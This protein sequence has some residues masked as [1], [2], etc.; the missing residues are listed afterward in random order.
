MNKIRFYIFGTPDGFDIYQE[1]PDANIT[2][3]YQCFYDESIKE[4]TRLAVHR[5][6]NGDVSYTFL[7]YHLFSSGNRS[8]AFIGL[9][10]VFSNGSYFD[11]SSLY[12]LLEYAYNDI[13][14]RGKLLETTSDGNSARFVTAKFS[15]EKQEVRRIE[16]FII[17]Q[18]NSEE[19]S[20]EFS[21]FDSSFEAGKQNAI[22]KIP[23]QIYND[24]I[25]EKRLNQLV[26]DSLKKYSWLSL[27][28]D[29]IKPDNQQPEQIIPIPTDINEELDPITKAQYVNSFES[30]QRDVLA[31]FKQLI[32]KADNG[33]IEKVKRL[34]KEIKGILLLLKKYSKMQ[35]DL[36]N[37][38]KKYSDLSET[39]DTL[40]AQLYP[41]TLKQKRCGQNK[42]NTE[43]IEYT[44][45]K[46]GKWQLYFVA[47]GVFVL[48]FILSFILIPDIT[49]HNDKTED[50]TEVTDSANT[51]TASVDS[52]LE[53]GINLDDLVADFNTA[54]LNNN[55]NEAVS[56]YS[57][58]YAQNANLKQNLDTA[59]TE[60][61]NSLISGHDFDS[62]H[63]LYLQLR[64][65]IIN[66]DSYLTN[67]KE[68][69]KNYI[70][71]NQTDLAQKENLINMIEQAKENN[72]AYTEIDDDLHNIQALS[73][74]NESQQCYTLTVHCIDDNIKM[75]KNSSDII[76]IEKGRLYSISITISGAIK[77]NPLLLNY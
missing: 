24:E 75:T 11:V 62:A 33:L 56:I 63:K 2:S 14:Q 57:Q 31:T 50:T 69:F 29:Y 36:Q 19:Y 26:I 55:F 17:N 22:L 44:K 74:S 25:E 45:Q 49:H 53:T 48:A 27:S 10:V 72:Y 65:I 32:S 21:A 76:E 23:F 58:V 71:T 1:A 41:K 18:L 40:K 42:T 7:K 6:V 35:N 43:N 13:L 54:L 52:H 4:N 66:A 30:Y 70:K 73:V 34:D 8:N 3:Y 61:F 67:L 5:K 15:N 59:L 20:I 60:K 28:P 46:E 37:L 77:I 16:S 38:L 64:N 51:Y 39:L 9:S 12:N 68:S 47:G